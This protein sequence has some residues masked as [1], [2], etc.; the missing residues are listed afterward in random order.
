MSSYASR[1]LTRISGAP[2]LDGPPLVLDADAP[3]L[4]HETARRQ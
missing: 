2:A 4:H 1:S 3:G